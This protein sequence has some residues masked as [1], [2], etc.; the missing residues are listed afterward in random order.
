MSQQ[1][2]EKVREAKKQKY[3][4]KEKEAKSR[5]YKEH[6]EKIATTRAE[7]KTTETKRDRFLKFKKDL[8]DCWSVGCICCHR[9]MSTT[10]G[11]YYSG[12]IRKVRQ[13]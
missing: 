3:G 1:T 6:K 10:G 12:G 9:K 5:F 11:K 7:K 8:K 13:T 4:Q 2:S